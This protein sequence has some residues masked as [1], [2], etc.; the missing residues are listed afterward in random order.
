MGPKKVPYIV[1]HDGRTIRFPH[2][3]IKKNDTIKLNLKTGDIIG[4]YKFELGVQVIITGGN[5]IGRVGTISKVEK[6]E[7]SYE[8]IH[9]KD[10]RLLFWRGDKSSLL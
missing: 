3:E 2:P 7:G 8:I 5:N 10:E 9:V 4:T 1:T 6:H